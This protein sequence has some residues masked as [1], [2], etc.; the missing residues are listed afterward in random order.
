MNE[1]TTSQGPTGNI[2]DDAAGSASKAIDATRAATEDLL[3]QVSDRV[4]GFRATL[5]P[6]LDNA[7][8]PLDPLLRFTREHPGAALIAATGVG[9]LLGALLRRPRRSRHR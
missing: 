3:D 6:A 9:A 1:T 5:S 8:Q 4:E 7:L 2:V